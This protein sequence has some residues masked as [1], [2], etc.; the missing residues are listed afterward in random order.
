M[1]EGKLTDADVEAVA[2]RVAELLHDDGATRPRGFVDTATV[3]RE[4]DLSV[5]WVR[6]HAAELGGVRIG[7]R[8]G[9]LRFEMKRVWAYIEGRRLTPPVPVRPPRRPG[10]QRRADGIELLPRPER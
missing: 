8:H 3:A 4:L 1:A 9:A 2:R 10:R 5:D 6:G 7:G